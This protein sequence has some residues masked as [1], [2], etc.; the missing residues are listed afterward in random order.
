MRT[1]GSAVEDAFDR[2]FGSRRSKRE[3]CNQ[4]ES[5]AIKSVEISHC[6]TR[7]SLSKVGKVE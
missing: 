1:A 2:A 4:V 7:Y 6:Y 5:Y 3:I